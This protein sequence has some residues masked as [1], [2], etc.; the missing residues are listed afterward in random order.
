MAADAA[1]RGATSFASGAAVAVLVVFAAGCGGSSSPGVASIGTS[2][3]ASAT[4]PSWAAFY[5]CFAAYGYPN[6][7]E[8]G[9][10][11]V[12]SAPPINGWYRKANGNYVV[13]PDFMKLY[14]TAKFRA[15]EKVC[16][17]LDP[18]PR[19]TPAEVARGAAQA[20]KFSRCARAHGMPNFPDPDNQGFIHLNAAGISYESPEFQRVKQACRSLIKVWRD[21]AGYLYGGPGFLGG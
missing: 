5:H 19:A 13:T 11:S 17:P 1:K 9:S 10:P 8:I 21:S 16:D 7:R 12:S 6:Y 15:V 20:R 18:S 2:T 4:K 14:F 3:D